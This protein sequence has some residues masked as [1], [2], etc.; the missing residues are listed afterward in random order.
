VSLLYTIL[1]NAMSALPPSTLNP[2]AAEARQLEEFRNFNFGS[3]T[4]E[5][6]DLFANADNLK[7]RHFGLVHRA[8]NDLAIQYVRRPRI[9]YSGA[10]DAQAE[11][12]ATLRRRLSIDAET[13]IA[14]Q[15]LV[16][17]QAYIS[18]CFLT[19]DGKSL[20]TANFCPY[21]VE[22]IEFADPF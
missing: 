13:L 11:A 16:A 8:S 6:A 15:Q 3:M 22:C 7:L 10:S 9:M 17:Q 5:M 18:V 19:P 21:D 14:E 1:E 12:F 2:D 20:R 4:A